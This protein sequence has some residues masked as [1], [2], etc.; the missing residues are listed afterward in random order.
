VSEEDK[1]HNSGMPAKW[2][3]GRKGCSYGAGET[4]KNGQKKRIMLQLTGLLGAGAHTFNETR[5]SERPR[6]P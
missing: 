1:G 6:E 4:L 2:T 5:N 3:I